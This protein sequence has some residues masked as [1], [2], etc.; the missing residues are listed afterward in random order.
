MG[1]KVGIQSQVQCP[2]FRALRYRSIVCESIV[3][4]GE[5]CC[6]YFTT[7]SRRASHVIWHCNEIDGAGCPVYDAVMRKYEEKKEQR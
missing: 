7:E 3:R 5:S 6:T 1:N 4:S 2:F